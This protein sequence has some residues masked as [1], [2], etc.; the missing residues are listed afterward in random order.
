MAQFNGEIKLQSKEGAG[1]GRGGVE[2]GKGNKGW[3]GGAIVL[4]KRMGMNA[5]KARRRGP[6]L[7]TLTMHAR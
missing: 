6:A 2:K 4:N 5:V 3:S 1:E 7:C